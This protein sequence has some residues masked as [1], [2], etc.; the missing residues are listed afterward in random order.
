MKKK[1]TFGKGPSLKWSIV[2]IVILS[3]SV[4]LMSFLLTSITNQILYIVLAGLGITIIAN[5][6]RAITLKQKFM[7][8]DF[9]MWLCINIFSFWF[10]GFLLGYVMIPDKIFYY[11]LMGLGM[12]AIGQI[13]Q[14]IQ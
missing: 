12:F 3:L 4:W 8:R 7:A 1:P 6:I 2:W 14:R 10:V 5:I 9:V 11:F 13:V